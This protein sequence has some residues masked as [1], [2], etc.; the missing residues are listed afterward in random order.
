M[1]KIWNKTKI[2]SK[3]KAEFIFK[4]KLEEYESRM[5]TYE[6]M[7][8]KLNDEHLKSN[9]IIVKLKSELWNLK[10]DQEKYYSEMEKLKEGKIDYFCVNLFGFCQ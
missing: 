5:K 7:I 2:D 1:K 6:E 4:L 3:N 8:K 10:D 9:E